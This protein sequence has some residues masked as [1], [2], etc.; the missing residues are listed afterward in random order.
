MGELR[1]A[2]RAFVSEGHPPEVI[3]GL[4]NDVLRRYHPG[5][6]ATL[7]LV[8]AQP[9]TGELTI[10]NCGHMPMLIADDSGARYAGEGGILLGL[11]RHEPHVEKAELSAG[12]TVLLFTDGLVEDRRV[13]LGDNLEKL[14][15]VAAEAA[16]QDVEAFA[17]QVMALFG[18]KEDDIAMIVLRRAD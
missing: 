14:R 11:T 17:N 3:T 5:V 8:L 6:I 18:P 9:A 7:C 15:G 10:V 2:L 1:H 12:G 13:L 4:V 16:N